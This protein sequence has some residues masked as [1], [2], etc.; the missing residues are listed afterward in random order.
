MEGHLRGVRATEGGQDALDTEREGEECPGLSLCSEYPASACHYDDQEASGCRKQ[1][2]DKHSLQKSTC[3]SFRVERWRGEAGIQGKQSQDGTISKQP[4]QCTL[5][6][7][8]IS[9]LPKCLN[10]QSRSLP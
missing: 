1:E 2:A 10:P 6:P 3:P 5:F 7:R 9:K 4:P 8:K